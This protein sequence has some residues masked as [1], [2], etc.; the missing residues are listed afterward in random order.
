LPY[1]PDREALTVAYLTAHRTTPLTGDAAV[2]TRMVPRVVVLHW[3]AG[4]TAE[5]AWRTFAPARLAGRPDLADAGA[6]NVGAHYLVDRDGTIVRLVPDDR[7]V[8]H[9]IGLN[10]VAIGIENV[11]GGKEWP[12]TDAQVAA[13]AALVRWL[14][15]R[16]PLTHLVGHSEYR[17]L[18]DE[19]FFEERDPAYRTTKPDPGADFL[20]KVRAEVAD[21]GLAGPD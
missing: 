3:T 15:A 7:V 1:G 13:N 14:A 9:C 8:R 10:H 19:P 16:H 18:E 4:P 20:G 2:D 21:L 5:S 6:L 12:L 17:G 11:G